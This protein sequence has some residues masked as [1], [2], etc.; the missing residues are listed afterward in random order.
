MKERK[1][2][3]QRLQEFKA[4]RERQKTRELQRNS[5]RTKARTAQQPTKE[6]ELRA[7][8]F[9]PVPDCALW[10]NANGIG[11]NPET[12][13]YSK[14][15]RIQTAGA[16]WKTERVVLWLFKGITPRYGYIVHLDGNDKNKTVENLQYQRIYNAL[17]H[18]TINRANLR[19][20]LRCYWEIGSKEKPITSDPFTRIRLKFIYQ[21]RNFAVMHHK[22]K[23]MQFFEHWILYSTIPTNKLPPET[24]T[25]RERQTIIAHLLNLFTSEICSDFQNGLLTLQPFHE[26]KR[27]KRQRETA[28]LHELGIKRKTAARLPKNIREGFVELGLQPVKL[29]FVDNSKVAQRVLM[30]RAKHELQTARHTLPPENAAQIE[31]LLQ[32]IENKVKALNIFD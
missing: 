23:G 5:Q 10:L 29:G 21:K 12:K 15:L 28:L 22:E 24:Y 26:T 3:E 18:E 11:Y 7:G 9:K 27:E 17:P 30:I 19:T 25:A 14:P 32:M 4:K 1:T 13:R 2:F 31:N 8:G 16:Q 6:R 20:A